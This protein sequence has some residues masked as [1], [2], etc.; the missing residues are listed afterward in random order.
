MIEIEMKTIQ[1]TKSTRI[2][3]NMNINPIRFH[4]IWM[5]FQDVL[6]CDLPSDGPQVLF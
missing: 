4:G 2:L 1:A 6:E 3:E 5:I